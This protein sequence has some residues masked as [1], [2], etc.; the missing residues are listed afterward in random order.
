MRQG[1]RAAIF[2][3]VTSAFAGLIVPIATAGLMAQPVLASSGSGISGP[4]AQAAVVPA[5][6]NAGALPQAQNGNVQQGNKVYRHPGGQAKL[7]QEK[8]DSQNLGQGQGIQQPGPALANIL[9]PSPGALAGINGISDAESFC[10]CYPP[11]GGVAAGPDYL[12]ATVNTAFK[13]WNIHDGT[14]AKPA[15]SLSSL[16]AANAG[17]LPN[18]SDPSALY[19]SGHFIIEALTYN[20]SY[21]SA[22]CL[23][24]SQTAN[25]TG[26][27]YV[28]AFGVTPN[29]NLLDFPQVAVGSDAIY[30]SGNQFANGATFTGA[31]AYAYEKG[32]IYSGTAARSIFYNVGNNAANH[33]ADTLYPARGVTAASTG[34]FIAT[35]NC[36]A[37][38]N[39]SVWKLT[40]P[41]GTPAFTLRGGVTVATY[42]QPPA[43]AQLGGGTIDSGDTRTL[44]GHMFNG[45]IYGTHTIG[46][47]PGTGTVDCVQ[48]YQVGN[49]DATPTKL[50]EG[51]IGGNSQ[52]RFYSTLAVDK[53]GDMTIGY[54][55]SSTSEYAG[56]RYTGR[57][58]GDALGT[59]QAEATLKAGE[60]NANGARWGD[61]SSESLAPDGCTVWHFE[62]Y[63]Q[64]GALWGTW[65]GSFA[66]NGCAAPPTPD[67][68][69]SASPPSQ[70][71]QVGS[72][73]SYNVA[74][75][76]TG[77]F[78]GA[79]SLSVSGLPSGATG[80]FNPQ[81]TTGST[82]TLTVNT[83]STTPAAT[84]TLTI[85]GASGSLSHTTS[86]SLQV[87]DFT[88]SISPAS[89]TVAQGASTTYTVTVN[90]TNGHSGAV[91][92]TTGPLPTGVTA[93]FN[94][95]PTTPTGTTST[96]TLT[97]SSTAPV[98]SGTSFTVTGTS[99]PLARSTSATLVVTAP[100]ASDFSLSASPAS[101]TVPQ[102]T[103]T[104]Y[105][106]T[107]TRTNGFSGAVTLS[108]GALPTGVTASFSPNPS[109]GT[110]STLTVTTATSTPTGT[111]TINITGTSG[112]LS[113]PTSVT[114]V[115]VV[116]DNCNNC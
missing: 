78:A 2:A 72:G 22:I 15:A 45:T 91:T 13:I 99:S 60:A 39:V 55:Y 21:T 66:F 95:N 53:A 7:D 74:I 57:L 35:D 28:Y 33:Q 76:R 58:A 67:Y 84:S 50:Q 68:T 17:C 86:V 27:W 5:V 23:A 8:A 54:A 110:S 100:P 104:S 52:Y 10:G 31:R 108:V 94:P 115:V 11:D 6:V 70:A 12:V 20:N 90:R 103:G 73:T 38:N 82:S 37:C 14:V 1:T 96:L 9:A 71:V 34:Y 102:G 89:Q 97:A 113:H 30:L 107:I 77:G 114:L 85:T 80:S 29:A 83:S 112:S 88:I 92:F 65:A 81:S 49:V 79:V 56:I 63:A 98:T 61:Y 4:F 69:L 25:P 42:N 41:W 40:N 64:A 48:W 106:I 116:N 62:E 93:S 101:Q 26:A 105:T 18:I 44:G 51:T 19:D 16:F 111:Y 47:N 32:P 87:T 59:V 3:T 46:C 36:N 75:N 109:T 43:A 24:A